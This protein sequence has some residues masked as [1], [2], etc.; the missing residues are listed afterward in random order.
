MAARSAQ[1]SGDMFAPESCLPSMYPCRCE[2]SI[3]GI[4]VAP[5]QSITCDW[6]VTRFCNSDQLPTAIMSCP[7]MAKASECWSKGFS[8]AFLKTLI[9][10]LILLKASYLSVNLGPKFSE[11]LPSST[12]DLI[13]RIRKV[14]FDDF[15]Y[16]CWRTV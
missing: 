16:V 15:L 10:A 8:E 2:S 1:C 13:A 11:L 9:S 14:Y 12:R 3:P 4:T 6:L 7:S 5:S